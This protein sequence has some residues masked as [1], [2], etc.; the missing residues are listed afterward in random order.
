M[1][2]A[3]CI[4]MK[5]LLVNY[6]EILND[7]TYYRCMLYV[8]ERHGALFFNPSPIWRSIKGWHSNWSEL[9][10]NTVN[11]IRK[12][13]GMMLLKNTESAKKTYTETAM[14]FYYQCNRLFLCWG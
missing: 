7:V 5:M 1:H 13:H 9:W 14:A 10:E 3:R 4:P 6:E 11:L 12:K 8:F 2:L